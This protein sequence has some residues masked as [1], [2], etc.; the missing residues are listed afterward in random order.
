MPEQTIPVEEIIVPCRFC[1][2][3]SSAVGKYAM[4]EGCFCYPNDREQ[5]LCAQHVI[6]ATPIGAM[7]LVVIYQPWFYQT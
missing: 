1:G 6:R 5:A 2:E 3:G 4:P 7:E